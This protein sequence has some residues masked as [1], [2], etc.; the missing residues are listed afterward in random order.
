M[1]E[2]KPKVRLTGKDGNAF[3]ILGKCQEVARKAKW[4]PEKIKE[5]SHK[6]TEGDYDHLLSVCC[7]YFDVS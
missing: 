6:A 1:N 5:W 7:E 4:T 2:K 3:V